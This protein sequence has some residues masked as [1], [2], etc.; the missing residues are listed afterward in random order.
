[1]NTRQRHAI[2]LPAALQ[3]AQY[4]FDVE[5]VEPLE[6]PAY[7]GSTLRG[8]LGH[9][10]KR[11]VCIE[12]DQRAC[13][14]CQ[15]GNI[16]PY[17]YIFETSPPDDSEVLKNLQDVPVPFLIEADDERRE[18]APGD[19]LTFDLVLV[20]RAINYAP[21]IVMAYQE[22]GRL[23][24]GTSRGKYVLQRVQSVHPWT[25][26]RETI[27]DGVEMERSRTMRLSAE[28][29]EARAAALEADRLTLRFTTPTRLKY[30]GEY[31]EEPAFHVIVRNL[32][33]RVSSLAYFHC[34][35]QWETGFREIIAA[36]ERVQTTSA[37]LEWQDWWRYSSRQERRINLGGFVGEVTYRGDVEPFLPLL[38]LG[39]LVHVGK[40]TVFGHGAYTVH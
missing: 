26:T 14:P 30:Q 4:R 11:K 20:G 17:G 33:R 25:G 2:D 37:D 28:S 13:S 3:V 24:L 19:R 22:L 1:M 23:G 16:C 10:L 21:Y 39:E 31:V 12:D 38:A 32:L 7:K 40:A 29:V 35:E 18:Y 15:M 5:A 9:A 6:L 36:A 8:G 27:Y 34:G